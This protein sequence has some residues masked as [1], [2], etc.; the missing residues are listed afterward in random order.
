MT[1]NTT[2]ARKRELYYQHS[3]ESLSSKRSKAAKSRWKLSSDLRSPSSACRDDSSSDLEDMSDGSDIE[4]DDVDLVPEM[5]SENQ[6]D[7]ASVA[8]RKKLQGITSDLHTQLPSHELDSLLLFVSSYEKAIYKKL[9][10]EN[11]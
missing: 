3:A 5:D 8:G 9:A 6:H 11:W 1:P 4:V 7:W 10:S 2:K